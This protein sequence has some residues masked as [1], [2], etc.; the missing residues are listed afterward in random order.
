MYVLLYSNYVHAERIFTRHLQ[1]VVQLKCTL[2]RRFKNSV[3]LTAGGSWRFQSR[4]SR[5]G[6]V[7]GRV[8]GATAGV[9]MAA[10]RVT[11]HSECPEGG[12]VRQESARYVV[13]GRALGHNWWIP[14]YWICSACVKPLPS[15]QGEMQ[16]KVVHL[17]LPDVG[18]LTVVY[19]VT[20]LIDP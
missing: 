18:K 17:T 16:S 6:V 13:T 2:L 14:R 11:G 4:G 8:A 1:Q 5:S 15:S 3:D 9:V 10:V 12:R 7:N 19:L 20:F